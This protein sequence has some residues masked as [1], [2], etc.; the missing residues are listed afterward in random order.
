MS[1]EKVAQVLYD[2]GF[3]GDDL[4]QMVAIGQRE[5]G[6]RP[7]AHRTNTDPAKMVGDFGLFQINYTND[8]A[9]MRAAIGMTDRSQLL[10]PMMNAKAAFY[11]YQ[12]GGLQPWT[13]GPGGFHEDG[14]PAYGTDVSAARAAVERAEGSG[15]IGQPFQPDE[16]D[17]NGA[18]SSAG[19]QRSQSI[20]DE[21]D[22]ASSPGATDQRPD[23]EKA[24]AANAGGVDTDHDMLPDHFELRYGLDPE[25]ADTDGDGITDGYEL[26]V[27]G[28]DPDN[29]D[30]DFDGLSD[31]LEIS[32]GLDP[33]EADN[34]DPDA[35][36]DFGDD[37]DID[38]DGD[39]ITDAGELLRGT[40][41]HD[42]DSDHDGIPDGDELVAGTDPLTANS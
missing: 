35:S 21:P 36:W 30:S 29:A 39:G 9:A 32:L 14:N 18:G 1:A 31:S 26:I 34:P 5:S 27:L 2:A 25:E 37:T 22:D 42:A 11:L 3:R 23:P 17:D 33:T 16:R 7:E 40:D 19:A 13:A 24:A 10:D 38:S 20:V 41:P 12:R 6:Y 4:V 28:T 8:T 15:L